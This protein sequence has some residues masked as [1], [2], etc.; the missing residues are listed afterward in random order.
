MLCLIQGCKL[1]ILVSLRVFGMESHSICPF[2]YRLGRCIKKFTKIAVKLAT[3]Y[4]E[5]DIPH[6]YYI[7]ILV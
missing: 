4:K 6:T 5:H 3:Q 1:Q 2:G 7:Q